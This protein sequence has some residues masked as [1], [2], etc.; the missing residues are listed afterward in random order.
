MLRQFADAILFANEAWRLQSLTDLDKL[1]DYDE[2]WGYGGEAQ[3][4]PVDAAGNPIL[5]AVPKSWIAA[6]NDGERW[7]WLL[8]TMVE[9][10]PSRR[11]DERLRGPASSNRNSVC[12]PSLNSV[13]ACPNEQK[14]IRTKRRTRQAFGLDTLGED[15]TIARLAT[16]IKRFK[17]PDDHNYI[18]LD[19]KVLADLA[20]NKTDPRGLDAARNLAMEFENRRQ[21]PRAAE[22]W[23]QA[24]ER[25][26]GDAHKTAQQRLA[27]IEG[28]WG[29]FE[30][31]MSQP[32]GRGATVD[33][34][35]RNATSAEFV[36]QEVD[37]RKL[38]D[39]VKAYLKSNPKQLRWEQLNVSDIGY[40]LIEDDQQKYIGAEVARWKL[41][42]QP[43]E[44]HFDKRITVST[45]LQKAGAY[46]RH[47]KRGRRQHFEDRY[48]ARRHGNRSQ[49]DA[50]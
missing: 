14:T 35:F 24:I 23:R 17:L 43:R 13:S 19:Q 46:L 12:K 34:R 38:L 7:R 3:G 30:S 20:T 31:V 29:Q 48:V 15:E 41:E 40:R 39:D 42:L 28:N 6:K 36:A 5:Y 8:E 16:G 47:R 22:Y 10:D 1:P 45:P 4:A 11:N 27:Q 9:W 26:T 50:G 18:K 49:T 25:S 37:V 33:F 2:G 44:K 21:Y 32:A